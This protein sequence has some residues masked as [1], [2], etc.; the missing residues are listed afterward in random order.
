MLDCTKNKSPEFVLDNSVWIFSSK[1]FSGSEDSKIMKLRFRDNGYAYEEN[2]ILKYP[3]S[4]NRF[5]KY[6]KINN[7]SFKILEIH[8][9]KLIMQNPKT[10]IIVTLYKL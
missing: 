7:Q 1:S 9:N 5:L 6:F 8:E 2:T 3:Y 4:Y 10:K